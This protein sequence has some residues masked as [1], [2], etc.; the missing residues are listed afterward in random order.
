MK[1]LFIII[2]L[3]SMSQLFAN[4]LYQTCMGCHGLKGEK[5]AMGKSKII[6]AMSKSD[7]K[8]ALLGFFVLF[9]FDFLKIKTSPY[10]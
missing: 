8:K 10:F 1:K 4:K 7:I 5:V 6:S 2:A 3:L 9:N